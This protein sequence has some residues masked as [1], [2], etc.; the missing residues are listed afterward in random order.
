M[1][2]FCLIYL[3][4]IFYILQSDQKWLLTEVELILA[5]NQL[6]GDSRAQEIGDKRT[7]RNNK[8]V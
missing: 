4:R 1:Q 6:K 3:L 2:K 5:S 7:K 8:N